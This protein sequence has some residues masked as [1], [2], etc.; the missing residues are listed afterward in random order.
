MK[1]TFHKDDGYVGKK[2]DEAFSVGVK[3]W[4]GEEAVVT[5]AWLITFPKLGMAELFLIDVKYDD[6]AD[7]LKLA[8]GQF[9]L[10]AE[11]FKNTL[12]IFQKDPDDMDILYWWLDTSIQLKVLDSPAFYYLLPR[13]VCRKWNM[14]LLKGLLIGR[15]TLIG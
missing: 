1:P 7:P 6:D 3:K 4:L 9:K 15:Q 14:S 10:Y 8:Y 11:Y 12:Y 13:S 2:L 5:D